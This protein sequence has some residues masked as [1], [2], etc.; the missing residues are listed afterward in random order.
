MRDSDERITAIF[1]PFLRGP[2]RFTYA[3]VNCNNCFII[4]LLEKKNYDEEGK[5]MKKERK[6]R[7][8]KCN[9]DLAGFELGT[10]GL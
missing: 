10:I 7:E 4:H 3:L 2:L 9:S 5:E 6:R 8:K 1:T